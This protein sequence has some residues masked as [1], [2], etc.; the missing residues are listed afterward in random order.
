[1]NLRSKAYV[2]VPDGDLFS[3]S[4][5]PAKFNVPHTTFMAARSRDRRT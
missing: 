1:L 5:R 2:D 3:H 4:H